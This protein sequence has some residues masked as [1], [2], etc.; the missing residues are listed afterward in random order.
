MSIVDRTHRTVGA[1]AVPYLM[2]LPSAVL[3]FGLILYPVVY[4]IRLS[5][6]RSQGLSGN[7]RFVGLGNYAYLLTDPEFLQ[8]LYQTLLWTVCVVGLTMV[9][10]VAIAIFL[11]IRFPGRRLLRAVVILPWGT[12]LALSAVMWKWVFDPNRGMA[13]ET[14]KALGIISTNIGWFNNPPIAFSI[15]V[16]VGVWVSVPFSTLGI[17]A[18]LQAI[19]NDVREAALL[20]GAVGWSMVR[21]ITLPLLRPVLG[22]ILILNI[23]AVFN[24]FPIIWILTKGGP[25]NSTDII[26]T[27][28]YKHAFNF[29][30]FGTA[31]AMAV[32]VF[33]VLLVTSLTY[34]RLMSRAS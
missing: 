33:V 5:L 6:F 21:R 14:L 24:S 2:L 20:D 27:Y 26:I 11:N 9:L 1:R 31:S 23:I 18:G 29:L 7:L 28:L 10:A 4:A 19:P 25:I 30:D 13:N 15:V 12:S 32:V 16:F 17:L 34:T 22:V 8:I 3:I